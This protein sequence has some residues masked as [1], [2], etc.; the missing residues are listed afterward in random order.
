ME[1]ELYT[2]RDKSRET[3]LQTQRMFYKDNSLILYKL[4]DLRDNL[5]DLVTK[6][7]KR[8]GY[9]LSSSV[10]ERIVRMTRYV[11]TT[12]TVCPGRGWG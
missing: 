6:E 4:L 10:E 3:V 12:R 7:Y 11:V 9:C 2:V 5:L 1:H 8:G